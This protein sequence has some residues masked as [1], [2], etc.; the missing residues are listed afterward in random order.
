[1]EDIRINE[2]IRDKYM[3]KPGV[4]LDYERD[5]T[6]YSSKLKSDFKEYTEFADNIKKFRAPN[7]ESSNYQLQKTFNE[8]LENR[9]K[10]KGLFNFLMNPYNININPFDNV[11]KKEA[12]VGVEEFIREKESYHLRKSTGVTLLPSAGD[13]DPRYEIYVQMNVIAGELND[14]N[15]SLVDCLYQGDSLGNKLEYLVNETLRNPWDI[16]SNRLF[17]DITEGDAAKEIETKR[18]EDDKPKSKEDDKLVEDE[19]KKGGKINYNMNTRKL[20]GDI[21]KTRKNKFYT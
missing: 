20:R 16:N 18:K 7:K 17:F 8:F 19:A 12:A 1:L 9:E 2:Y 6:K 5:D 14:E 3:F 4:D 13:N 10:Y 15:K 11:K 21:I